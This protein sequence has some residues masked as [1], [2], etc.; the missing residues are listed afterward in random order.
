MYFVFVLILI[1]GGLYLSKQEDNR[2]KYESDCAEICLPDKS[3]TKEFTCYCI[4][5]DHQLRKT[6]F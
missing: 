2:K 4:N 1:F 5:S 3:V 6:E